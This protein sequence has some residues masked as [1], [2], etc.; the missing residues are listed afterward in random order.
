MHKT[1]H[2]V[3]KKAPPVTWAKISAFYE[4]ALI[5]TVFFLLPLIMTEHLRDNY[6]VIKWKLVHLFAV[7]AVFQLFFGHK[8]LHLPDLG[9]P[10]T[11]I[12]LSIMGLWGW[13]Y[14]FHHIPFLSSVTVDRTAFL[15]LTL[16]FYKKFKESPQTLDLISHALI[17]SMGVFIFLIFKQD[18]LSFPELFS[19]DLS[20]SIRKKIQFTFGNENMTA[21][22]FGVVLLCTFRQI[23]VRK[24]LWEKV[25]HTILSFIIALFLI[26]T[27]C[28]SILVGVGMG[29]AFYAS[30]RC[31]PPYRAYILKAGL[32][33]GLVLLALTLG[34]RTKTIHHRQEMWSNA[35]MMA[36]DYPFGIGRERFNFHHVLYQQA[37]QVQPRSEGLIE[38]TPHN[39]ALKYLVEEGW[40]FVILVFILLALFLRTYGTVLLK[41]LKKEE[42]LQL[43][44]GLFF[45]LG[46]EFCVQF[47]FEVSFP[48]LMFTC[49]F[50][51]ILSIIPGEKRIALP[52][53]LGVPIFCLFLTAISFLII[54]N[55]GHGSK[56]FEPFVTKLGCTL[57]P[58]EWRTCDQY[59]QRLEEEERHEAVIQE[60]LEQLERRPYNFTA[61]VQLT[62]AYFMGQNIKMACKF[63]WFYDRLFYHNSQLHGF[64]RAGCPQ[65]EEEPFLSLS[66]KDH[67][68]GLFNH[69]P[70]DQQKRLTCSA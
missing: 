37:D 43:M 29:A 55:L 57:A 51:Y 53:A 30:M 60:G 66:L 61:L 9:K 24:A 69:L 44:G 46:A 39:E 3:L 64:I 5:A 65:S 70:K 63:A 42:H 48:Y 34:V 25:I 28:R 68:R 59:V 50:G 45:I 20:P 1:I 49:F 52:P 12:F 54:A 15:G 38:R 41:S 18:I 11:F 62:R 22:F 19:Y 2:T 35:V 33:L 8:K 58:Y 27:G 31:D 36:K 6:T 21:Q 14:Y 16:F 40:I 56:R 17:A 10:I 32:L 4:K 67:Y 13:E 47:P 7:L 23:F 26:K